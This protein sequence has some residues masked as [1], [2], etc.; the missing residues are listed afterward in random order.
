[1]LCS[2]QVWVWLFNQSYSSKGLRLLRSLGPGTHFLVAALFRVVGQIIVRGIHSSDLFIEDDSEDQRG[3]G[4]G[5]TVQVAS[6]KAA[7]PTKADEVTDVPE[8]ETETTADMVGGAVK[9]E[10]KQD[11][12]DVIAG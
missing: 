4:G 10:E 3:E 9:D 8:A 12:G 1:M 11:E 2:E 7:A 5:G 6:T